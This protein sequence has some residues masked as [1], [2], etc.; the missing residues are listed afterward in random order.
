ME[1][2]VAVMDAT[3][4]L[5]KSR[6][7]GRLIMEKLTGTR[8]GMIMDAENGLLEEI[9]R[10]QE[11]LANI[12]QAETLIEKDSSHQGFGDAQRRRELSDETDF[13]DST[14]AHEN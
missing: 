13:L 9:K 6:P 2:P 14:L 3:L 11:R 10:N 5:G 12:E 1:Q 8:S 7:M 4:L